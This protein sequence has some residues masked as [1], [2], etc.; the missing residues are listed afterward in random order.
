MKIIPAGATS[1]VPMVYL[2]GR[3]GEHGGGSWEIEGC[4]AH[5]ATPAGWDV[6]LC[7]PISNLL[8]VTVPTGITGNFR[9]WYWRDNGAA[10]QGDILVLATDEFPAPGS[11][12]GHQPSTTDVAALQGTPTRL[13]IARPG[14]AD[15]THQWIQRVMASAEWEGDHWSINR[16]ELAEWI[17]LPDVIPSRESV[18]VAV[19]AIGY[20]IT[21]EKIL[22]DGQHCIYVRKAPEEKCR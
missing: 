3:D 18:P 4:E 8:R 15:D 21:S 5:N 1:D 6:I 13:M 10:W 12:L 11:G 14:G 9:V 7:G 19:G 17:G 20:K 2:T 16:A 22:I